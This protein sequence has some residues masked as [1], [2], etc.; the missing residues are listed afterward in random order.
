MSDPGEEAVDEEAPQ[1]DSIRLFLPDMGTE[2]IEIFAGAVRST[3]HAKRILLSPER[4]ARE[5]REP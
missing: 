4:H 1:F 2:R 5:P 3:H